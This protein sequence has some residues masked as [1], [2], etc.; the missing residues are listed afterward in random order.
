[1]NEGAELPD[2]V[3]AA[4]RAKRK[5]AAIKLLREHRGLS[6]KEAKEQVEAYLRNHPDLAATNPPRVESGMGRLI[7]ICIA[8]VVLYLVYNYF[9]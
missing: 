5:I 9:S 6:L 2:D 4:V 1:M 8:A 3:I 7:I